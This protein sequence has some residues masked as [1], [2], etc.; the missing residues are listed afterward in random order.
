M[1]PKE[2]EQFASKVGWSNPPLAAAEQREKGKQKRA[3]AAA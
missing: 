1:T 3:Q 2:L